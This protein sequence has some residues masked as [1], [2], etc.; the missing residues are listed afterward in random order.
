[1]VLR[2]IEP[3]VRLSNCAE[4]ILEHE[5]VIDFTVTKFLRSQSPARQDYN[6]LL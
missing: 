6:N 4:F 2:I 1:M 5:Y 3:W